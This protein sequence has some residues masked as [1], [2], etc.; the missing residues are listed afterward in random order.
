MSARDLLITT[1][2]QLVADEGHLPSLDQLARA[3]GLSK[4][5][6]MHHLPS[7]AAL[8]H[9]LIIAAIDETDRA[10]ADAA[11]AGRVVDTWMSLSAETT[12]GGTPIAALARIALDA[13]DGLG[14]TADELARATQRW[15][16]LLAAELGSLEKAR[17]VRLIGDGML[18]GR[19]IDDRA[20]VVTAEQVMAVV[21]RAL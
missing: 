11:S 15:E 2:R 12:I 4:G 14:A 1:A 9:A 19:L 13:R 18:L 6:V 16:S 8:V 17:M 21:G 20:P 5:G 7:R 3:T 10:L